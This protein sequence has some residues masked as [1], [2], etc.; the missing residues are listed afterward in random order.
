VQELAKLLREQYTEHELRAFVERESS[1]EDA[2]L[3][4]DKRAVRRV[5][6]LQAYLDG[7]ARSLHQSRSAPQSGRKI[8]W[9]PTF[10]RLW[11][12]LGFLFSARIRERVWTPSIEE[13]KRDYAMARKKYRT[14]K[15]RGWIKLCFAIQT[16]VL[17]L[18]T[19]KSSLLGMLWAFV[20]LHLKAII[21][22][23]WQLP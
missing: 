12:L 2:A 9:L 16:A 15:S 21:R 22:Q 8:N 19:W 6:F 4:K 17:V 18:Q 3:D 13:M 10:G 14:T 11:D 20:P 5:Y 23:F 1:R 7:F